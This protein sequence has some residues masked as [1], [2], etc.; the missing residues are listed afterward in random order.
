MRK[1]GSGKYTDWESMKS[2]GYDY[3]D[4]GEFINTD[5]H[6]FSLNEEEFRVFMLEERCEIEEAGLSVYQTHGPWRCPPQDGTKEERAER[7]E[8]MKRSIRGTAYLGGKCMVIH[9]IMPFGLGPDRA[10]D[11]WQENKLFFAELLK[12]AKEE[13][14]IICLENMPFRDFPMSSAEQIYAFVKEM[15]SPWFQMCLDTGHCMCKGES[16]AEALKLCGDKVKALHIHDN[17]G[18]NDWHWIP[19]LGNVDWDAFRDELRN[20]PE[21]VPLNLETAIKAEIPEELRKYFNKGLVKIA[22]YLVE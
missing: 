10:D 1:L 6:I 3:V 8:K 16:P 4:Y 12:T 7:M 18:N 21:D 22:R 15:N 9:P 17:D 2:H 11:V 13:K 19:F 20:I 14:V 5:N